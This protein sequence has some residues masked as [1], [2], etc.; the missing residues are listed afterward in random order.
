VPRD[1]KALRAWLDA[2]PPLGQPFQAAC[3]L[4]PSEQA[5]LFALLSASPSR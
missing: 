3:A 1:L 5:R 4:A 2:S